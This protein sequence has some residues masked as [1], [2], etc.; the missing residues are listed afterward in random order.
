MARDDGFAGN[1]LSQS[2]NAWRALDDM[3][4]DWLRRFQLAVAHHGMA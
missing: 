2:V 1:T 4:V 3:Q